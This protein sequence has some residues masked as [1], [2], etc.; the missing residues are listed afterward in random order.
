MIWFG[1]LVSPLANSVL[2]PQQYS[3]DAAPK[4]ISERT[5][6]HG[7]WLAF[8]PYP[9]V[10]PTVFNLYGFGPPRGFTPASTCS[11]IAHPVS[12]LRHAT[13]RP[14]Q[15]RFP[16][17]YTWRLNLA[18]HRN[19][20][21]H[22]ARGTRSSFTIALS[23][24]VSIW[25]EVLFHSPY[26]GSFHLS[27]TVLVHY[28]SA[29]SILAWRVVPPDSDKISRVPSYSGYSSVVCNF[30]YGTFTPYGVPSQTLLLSQISLIWVLQPQ[31]ASI[32]VW[33]LPRSLAATSGISF[34]Y[35]SSRY[36]DVSVP[37][38]RST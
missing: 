21:A 20:M 16:Y 30:G 3:L 14:I 15:T 23:L 2:Y 22:N 31:H 29:R 24:L 17:G 11:W 33:P 36:L 5:S 13:N 35:S 27:L 37:S 34:D 18:T 10:I 6:N 1:K 25:F 7:I 4:C 19:S 38:V 12:G 28:R 9:Q 26:R 8:H 32:L